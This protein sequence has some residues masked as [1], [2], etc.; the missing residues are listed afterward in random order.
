MEYSFVYTHTMTYLL[1][2]SVVTPC[3]FCCDAFKN[4]R[5]KEQHQ[6]LCNNDVVKI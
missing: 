3:C 4:L 6:T 5:N 2:Y 1:L